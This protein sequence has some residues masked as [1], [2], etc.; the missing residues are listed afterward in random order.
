MPRTLSVFVDW[1]NT[2]NFARAPCITRPT[3]VTSFDVREFV[4]LSWAPLQ[5][6]MHSAV[7]DSVSCG[8]VF[9]EVENRTGL[10][11]K[12][13]TAL[14]QS[15]IDTVLSRTRRL[16]NAS[17]GSPPSCHDLGVLLSPS[18]LRG[19]FLDGFWR[20]WLTFRPR[21]P[22]STWRRIDQP[23]PEGTELSDPKLFRFEHRLLGWVLLEQLDLGT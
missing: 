4:T 9:D 15:V 18:Q 23:K 5:S 19:Y 17:S 11:C 10:I 20:S 22:L 6:S 16:A 14:S 3:L 8:G 21:I 12:W 13:A 1:S 7:V 2:D